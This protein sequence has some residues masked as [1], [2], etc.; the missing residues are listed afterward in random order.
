MR[1]RLA[2]LRQQLPSG[3]RLKE[4]RDGWLFATPFLLGLLL[5]WVGPMGYSLYLTLHEWDLIAKPE[6]AGFANYAAL[7]SDRLLGT[8]L[9]NTAYYTF[10]S[11]PLQLLLALVLAIAL[12]RGLR[13]E[14]TFRTILYLPSI[15]PAVASAVVWTQIYNSEYGVLNQILLALGLEPVRWLFIPALAKPAFIFM[16]L[17]TIGPQ[18]VILLAGLQN[19][20]QQMLEAAEID[21]AGAWDRFRYVT[22]PMLSPSLFFNLVIGLIGSFQVFTSAFIMTRGGPQ[23]ATLFLVLYLYQNGFN[24]FKMGYAATLSWVLF[25]IVMAL[26]LLQLRL[27]DRWVYYEVGA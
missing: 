11:V 13:A 6:F 15:T 14:S 8:T 26:T 9:W 23:N 5:Y 1:T 18:M 16:S 22:L 27:S 20:P 12:N 17:W 10:V 24:L 7:F 25:A 21:G 19:I 3:V 4:W 2:K